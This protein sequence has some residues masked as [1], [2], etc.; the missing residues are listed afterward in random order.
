M[1]QREQV[2]W[3]AFEYELE[4]IAEQEGRSWK[5]DLP[6]AASGSALTTGALWALPV[7]YS[8]K[9]ARYAAL[10]AAIPSVLRNRKAAYRSYL[11][12]KRQGFRGQD[13][14]YETLAGLGRKGK[15]LGTA[16]RVTMSGLDTAG[17][18]AMPTAIGVGA[19]VGGLAA[20]R[21]IKQKINERRERLAAGHHRG[22]RRP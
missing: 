19:T 1:G 10:P 12:A 22:H 16:T 5:K 3:A 15:P 9:A 4:K 18:L 17:F 8:D 7:R 14:A 6:A 20:S 11:V 2:M 21:K 13:L